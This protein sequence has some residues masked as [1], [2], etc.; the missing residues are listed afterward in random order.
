MESTMTG[1]LELFMDQIEDQLLNSMFTHIQSVQFHLLSLWNR[2][3]RL[4]LKTVKITYWTAA[5]QQAVKSLR[6]SIKKV[7]NT[8]NVLPLL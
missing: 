1:I 8:H 7:S 3:T 6:V 2:D 5:D 4:M